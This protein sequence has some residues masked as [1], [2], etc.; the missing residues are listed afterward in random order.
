[1]FQQVDD[2]AQRDFRSEEVF[3]ST[4]VEQ[5][6][7]RWLVNQQASKESRLLGG[8]PKSNYSPKGVAQNV[9][10]AQTQIIDEP[11][12]VGH[13]FRNV[14]WADRSL[15]LAVASSVVSDDPEA[16]TECRDDCVPVAVIDP[17]A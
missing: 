4:H 2:C 15:T 3:A 1:M 7:E 17:G 9:G 14:A 11:T 8:E 12:K 13:I 5:A 6:E 10:G 16:A